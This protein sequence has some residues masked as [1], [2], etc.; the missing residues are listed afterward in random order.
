MVKSRDFTKQR[1][2][3]PKGQSESVY[4]RIE[5]TM[6]KRKKIQKD[7]QRST[8][9]TYKVKVRVTR[10]PL[11]PGEFR[12]SSGTRRVNLVT[13]P[14][15]SRQCGKDQEVFTTSGTYR[16]SFF[17]RYSVTVKQVMVATV[18]CSKWW[19][20][21][22]LPKGTLGSVSSL[23]AAYF[24]KD[25]MIG[26]TSYGISYH[27]RDI[28]SIC[29]YAAGMLLH[30]NGKFA[31]GKLKSSPCR[32]VPFLTAPHCLFWGVGQETKQTYLYLWNPLLEAQC[33][34]CDQQNYSVNEHHHNS[35]TWNKRIGLA[36][37]RFTM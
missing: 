34:R 26:A 32:K 8:K 18:T 6:A 17:H 28:Y 20:Y 35:G 2:K 9:H 5:N 3:I 31:M 30:I 19:L 7:K 16:G 22:T 10:I 33:D 37:F 25:S 14:I 23:L 4:R 36:S 29:I 21:Q 27:L 11:K 15:I 13:N 24:I 1:L 12:Y